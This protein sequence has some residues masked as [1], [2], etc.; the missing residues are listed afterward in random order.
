MQQPDNSQIVVSVPDRNNYPSL[1][2]APNTS[3]VEQFRR[4]M[5]DAIA[6]PD[7]IP[8]LT[9]TAATHV[10]IPAFISSLWDILPL[11]VRLFF[12]LGVL[13][14]SSF[15]L[16]V[17]TIPECRVF[18]IFRGVLVLLGAVLGLHP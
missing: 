3:R 6:L 15:C 5:S 8:D 10:T 12:V 2:T 13:I 4:G 7:N 11:I 16:I 9:Y 18:L 17:W 14:L 1:P